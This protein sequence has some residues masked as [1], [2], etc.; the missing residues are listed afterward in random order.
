MTWNI[1]LR[2]EVIFAHY[3]LFCWPVRYFFFFLMDGKQEIPL[4]FWT[5]CSA[6]SSRIRFIRPV[7]Q[8]SLILW[9]LKCIVFCFRCKITSVT[10][11]CETKDIFWCQHVVALSLYRIRNA[12]SVRLRV[13]ISGES[14]FLYFCSLH[15]SK[16]LRGLASPFISTHALTFLEVTLY[17]GHS[18]APKTISANTAS[19]SP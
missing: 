11:S 14:P 19:A 18:I 8:A 13:P 5:I 1:H 12:D 6:F 15:R 3:A 4:Q 16:K 7:F 9:D 17:G 10:C 2:V